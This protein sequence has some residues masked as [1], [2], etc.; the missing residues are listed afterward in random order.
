MTQHTYSAEVG[1]KFN[2]DGSVRAFAGNTVICFVAPD[3]AQ[4]TELLWAQARL[5]QTCGD[6]ITLL[7]P[8]SLHMT[9][10]EGICDQTRVREKWFATLPLD[11][12][13]SATDAHMR[14][15]VPSIAPPQKSAMRF[16]RVNV[17]PSGISI[18]LVPADEQTRDELKRYRDDVSRAT[19]LRFPNHDS[20]V[21][22]ISL[23]YRILLWDAAQESEVN[24][25]LAEI[26][27]R[28]AKTFGVFVPD[29]PQLVFF[30]DMFEFLPQRR[31]ASK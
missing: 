16:E 30:E 14:R 27:V 28:F 20:Y 18:T 23:S 22:H 25:A 17:A 29:A 8:S 26:N 9:V 31:S 24:G 2:A 7:P 4:F 3:T 1:R 11:A 13:L 5:K 12:P 15:T 6:S 21:F 19:G 10:I